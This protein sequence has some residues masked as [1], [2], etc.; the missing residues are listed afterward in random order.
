MRPS[1]QKLF[2]KL[3]FLPVLEARG[4][5]ANLLRLHQER[6]LREVQRLFVAFLLALVRRR[7][8]SV[9]KLRFGTVSP[10]AGRSKLIDR[11]PPRR[12]RVIM[13]VPRMAPYAEATI[14]GPAGPSC[15]AVRATM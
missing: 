5:I 6:G 4:L 1:G 10:G 15:G 2:V 13:N 14:H 7:H 8:D 11:Q 3:T 12:K 9:A